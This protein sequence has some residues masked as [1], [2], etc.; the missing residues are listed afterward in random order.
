MALAKQESKTRMQLVTSR[1]EEARAL[2]DLQVRKTAVAGDRKRM[3][4]EAGPVRYLAQL[5]WG[6]DADLEKTV[7]LLILV[8]AGVFDPLAVLLL[9]AATRY[10][11]KRA[12]RIPHTP[13]SSR[14]A[15]FPAK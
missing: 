11:M 5:V 1:L 8:I 14:K 3:E 2:A 6:A 13:T 9:I 7:R 12:D 4:A 15:G 10:E